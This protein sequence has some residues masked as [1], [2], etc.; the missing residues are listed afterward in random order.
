VLP[1]VEQPCE[2]NEPIANSRA[3]LWAQVAGVHPSSLHSDV[4]FI[5]RPSRGAGT[6]S[7]RKRS[8]RAIHGYGIA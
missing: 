7:D 6:R 5:A 8:G 3:L 2:R 1:L 4:E